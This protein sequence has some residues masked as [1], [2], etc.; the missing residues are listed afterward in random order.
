MKFFLLILLI[1]IVALVYNRSVLKVGGEQDVKNAF[2][3]LFKDKSHILMVKDKNNEW[4]IPGGIIDDKDATP[5]NAALREFHEETDHKLTNYE[6]LAVFDYA[7]KNISRVDLNKK[8]Y[9]KG[10]GHSRIF[11]VKTNDEIASKKTKN[12][13]MKERKWYN[14]YDTL[15]DPETGRT[16]E[17]KMRSVAW[18]SFYPIT[19]TGIFDHLSEHDDLTNWIPTP[20]KPLC[21]HGS[22]CY[23]INDP[24]HSQK[25]RHV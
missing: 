12:N 25:Y 7:K 23:Y 1:L 20:V 9:L 19:L 22:E 21:K 15:F 4:Q 14:W 3:I 8:D 18:D 11:I 13:E 6:V 2:I 17:E 16:M 10:E 5:L 24:D